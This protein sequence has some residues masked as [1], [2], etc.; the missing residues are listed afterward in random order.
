M[1]QGG[2]EMT[3]EKGKLLVVDDEESHRIMLR[4]VLQEEGYDVTEAADGPEGIKAVEEGPF[5]VILLDIR[6]PTLGGIETLTEIRKISPFTPVLMMTA[7]ASVKTAVEALRAGAFDYLTK[8]LDIEELKILVEKALEHYHLREENLSLRERLGDRF[9]FSKIIGKSRKMKELFELLSQVAPTDATVLILGESGTGK[10]LVANAIHQ[11]SPRSRGPFI[12]VACAALPETLLESELFGH[13]R[14][15]F[16]GAVARREGRFQAAHR[17]TIF[18]DEV[19]EMS[20][21]TQAKLLR[22]L[23]EKEFEPLG[24]TRTTKVDVR[25]IAATNKDLTAEVKE[26]RFREDLYYRLNVVP[27]LL[28]PL[29]ER[30]EDIP[31]LAVHFFT[32]YRDKNRKELKEISGKT[33]D[34]LVR[35]DWPGNIREL[36]NCIERGVIMARGDIIAPADLPASILALSQEKPD[37]G[38]SFPSGISLEE[39]EKALILK[40]LE[41]TG[42]NRSRAAEIL[43][44]N[45]RTLQ[46][47]LKEYNL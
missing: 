2:L 18:L 24:S 35:Y 45:R 21:A 10:E 39:M 46:L 8:P 15:A 6:L 43:G 16:T 29:R 26:G 1:I 41:D 23:Q 11:N 38:I 4:A 17:G 19:G 42:G 14:G 47:K 22:V 13:E 40:T 44:I 36:E 3:K 30:K 20:P 37:S 5:D 25:V 9:D 34:L 32:I 31:A 12:K 27:V 28:P 33:L 7:Y